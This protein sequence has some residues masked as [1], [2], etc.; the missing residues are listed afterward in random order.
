MIKPY[1]PH[2]KDYLQKL[3]SEYQTH[4]DALTDEQKQTADRRCA[5]LIIQT[6]LRQGAI[7]AELHDRF[8]RWAGRHHE[9]K[10]VAGALSTMQSH[11]SVSE[12]E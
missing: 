4:Y 11:Y 8:C 9:H 3:L 7:S 6:F 10:H 1:Y 2:K 12:M 5:Q